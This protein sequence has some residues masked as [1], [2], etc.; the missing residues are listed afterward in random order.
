MDISTHGHFNPLTFRPMD[1]NTF[2]SDKASSPSKQTN[3]QGKN[4][5][6]Q[7]GAELGQAQCLA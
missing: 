6:Q 4:K 2:N 3:E 7:A 5:K 1:S